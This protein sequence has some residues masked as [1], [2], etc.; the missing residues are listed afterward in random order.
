MAV[1]EW[2][3]W[4]AAIVAFALA[5]N[6]IAKFFGYE[7]TTA[8]QKLEVFKADQA[9]YHRAQDS[10][11]QVHDAAEARQDSTIIA[12]LAQI[13]DRQRETDH[14]LEDVLIGECAENARSEL[15]ARRRFDLIAW[16]QANNVPFK[17]EGQ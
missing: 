6:G 13:Q 11:R 12:K 7:R 5:T 1:P 8:E 9:G 2:L 4:P 15:A 14:H 17:P 3:K 10:A 16:C